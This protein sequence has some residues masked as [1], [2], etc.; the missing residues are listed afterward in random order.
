MGYCAVSEP[1]TGTRE[2]GRFALLRKPALQR[3]SLCRAPDRDRG[4][5]KFLLGCFVAIRS[6]APPG[7]RAVPVFGPFASPREFEFRCVAGPEGDS[8]AT[9]ARPRPNPRKRMTLSE[10]LVNN[11]AP[12]VAPQA[13]FA[14]GDLEIL[15]HGET[16]VDRRH[17][18][19]GDTGCGGGRSPAGRIR[20]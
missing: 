1:S 9:S 11:I 15:N 5:Q 13:G 19:G 6:Y 14:G 10:S 8:L 2:K 3:V 12:Q 7:V 17:P 16:H 4:R 18:P 20:F